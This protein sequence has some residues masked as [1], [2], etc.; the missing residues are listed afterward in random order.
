MRLEVHDFEPPKPNHL[1]ELLVRAL[2]IST[3]SS[4]SQRCWVAAL[5]DSR[6]EYPDKY[7]SSVVHYTRA[8]PETKWRA[9]PTLKPITICPCSIDHFSKSYQDIVQY[10]AR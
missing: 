1:S 10:M 3:Y 5:I 9:P 6:F 4:D 2:F 7:V 8:T